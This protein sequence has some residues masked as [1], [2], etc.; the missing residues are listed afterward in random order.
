M[1]DLATIQEQNENKT[2]ME[3]GTCNKTRSFQV[4]EDVS[5]QVPKKRKKRTTW[6]SSFGKKE[7][8]RRW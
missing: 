7:L 4:G 3:V 1:N 5:T 6:S 2:E 8:R